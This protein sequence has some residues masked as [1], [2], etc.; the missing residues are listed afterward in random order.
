MNKWKIVTAASL[1]LAVMMSSACMRIALREQ[2]RREQVDLVYKDFVVQLYNS[3]NFNYKE[4]D[5]E[6]QIRTYATGIASLRTAY[7]IYPLTSYH[8][9]Y[10]FTDDSLSLL[11]PV[12]VKRF[13]QN[14][15]TYG[16]DFDLY[17]LLIEYAM[18]PDDKERVDALMDYVDRMK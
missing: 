2:E 3:F 1:C 17:N 13:E 4:A 6:E 15:Q 10:P 12:L 9:S 8:R 14:P 5:R 11:L 18:A 16:D 7:G